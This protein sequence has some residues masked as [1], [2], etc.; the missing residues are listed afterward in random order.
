M[1]ILSLG[2]ILGRILAVDTVNKQDLQKYRLNQIP[3]QLAEKEERLKGLGESPEAIAAEMAKTEAK[4][5][6]SAI[7]CVPF[8]SANDRSRWCTIRAL[9]EP[10]MRVAGAPYAI[11]KVRLLRGWDTIDMV[12]HDGHYYSSKPPLLPTM[13]AGVYW[14]LFNVFGLSFAENLYPV[15]ILVLACVNLP[16]MALFLWSVTKL[17]ELFGK[18]DRSKLFIV[19]VACFATFLSTFCVT[20][21]NHL[22]A[23]ACAAAAIYLTMKM[24]LSG[25]FRL[26]NSFMIGILSMFFVINELPSLSLF[27]ALFLILLLYLPWKSNFRNAVQHLLLWVFGVLVVLTPILGTNHIAHDSFRPPYMHRKNGDNWYEYS[28]E[29]SNGKVV[30]SY[31][32]DPK[33]L[34]VGEPSRAKYAF[35][36]LIGHHGIFSLTPIWLFAMAGAVLMLRSKERAI[37]LFGLLVLGLTLLIVTFYVMRPLGDR[38]YGGNT[39]GLRWTFWLIPLWLSAMLP[40]LERIENRPILWKAALLCLLFSALSVSFPTWNPWT[41]PWLFQG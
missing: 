14:I 31:W 30:K 17:A 18:S 25:E 36:V 39:C 11:D 22:P 3:K 32:Q 33:G 24:V 5:K 16:F 28:Y 41:H 9:V 34:D 2:L 7:L 12:K 26:E 13:M 1:I 38:N 35:H 27:A 37:Q 21:N 40:A 6:E 29:T 19:A 4:L 8:F 15:C 23:A 10:E 20:L